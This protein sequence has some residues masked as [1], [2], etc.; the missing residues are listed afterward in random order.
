MMA[1]DEFQDELAG[2]I[3]AEAEFEGP[4]QLAAFPTPAFA[5]RDVTDDKRYTGAQL[6]SAKLLNSAPTL[7]TIDAS[8]GS[9]YS[10]AYVAPC[11]GTP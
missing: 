8:A 9:S 4:E 1:V 2:L 5:V 7:V 10:L 6:V 11:S 3:L